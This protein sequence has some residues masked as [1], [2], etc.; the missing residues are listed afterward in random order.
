MDLMGSTITI[1]SVLV[2]VGALIGVLNYISNR[3]KNIKK[4]ASEDE[5]R[6]VRM[7]TMLVNIEK[8]TSSLNLRV[9]DHDKWLTKHETR[10]SVIEQ[11]M[12]IKKGD[13]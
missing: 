10:I 8:N 5:A 2:I 9:N 11:E 4:E 3:N 1:S 12:N 6:L 7:E 13:K